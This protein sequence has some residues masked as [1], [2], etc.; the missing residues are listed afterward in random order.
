[1]KTLS[2]AEAGMV[3]DGKF[4]TGARIGEAPMYTPFSKGFMHLVSEKALFRGVG[5]LIVRGAFF[6]AGN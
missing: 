5:T 1:M 6:S 4:T 2:Q 3:V